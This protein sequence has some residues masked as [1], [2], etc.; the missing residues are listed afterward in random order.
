MTWKRPIITIALLCGGCSLQS[1]PSQHASAPAPAAVAPQ[2]P[3]IVRVVS[4]DMTITAHAGPTGPIYAVQSEDGQTLVP[5]QS[6]HELQVNEPTL[7]RHIRTMQAE[8]W[9]GLD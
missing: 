8:G 4:R 2:A 1:Q 6:L 5:S 9:A 7:A 3:V